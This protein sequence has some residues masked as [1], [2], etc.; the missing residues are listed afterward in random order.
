[1]GSKTI[2]DANDFL[3]MDKRKSKYL[4]FVT[5]KK[6]S[7]IFICACPFKFLEMSCLLCM[8]AKSLDFSVSHL[9]KAHRFQP[10]QRK[11]I[12]TESYHS[13]IPDLA[14]SMSV[15]YLPHFSLSK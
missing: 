9:A 13:I 7:Y 10:F 2:L 8:L 14:F 6:E 15:C 4:L 11:Q 12:I 1:M 5:Q 3:C